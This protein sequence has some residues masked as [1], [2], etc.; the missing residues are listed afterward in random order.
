MKDN[1]TLSNYATSEET[2]Q[3]AKDYEAEYLLCLGV[4]G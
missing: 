2:E 3:A 4:K 1:L